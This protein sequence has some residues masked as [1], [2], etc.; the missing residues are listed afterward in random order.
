[1]TAREAH[2]IE[3]ARAALRWFDNRLKGNARNAMNDDIL[4]ARGLFNALARY[5]DAPAVA[6][7]D[8]DDPIT[9]VV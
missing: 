6:D 1:M 4:A 3:V 8:R 9:D 5:P 2:L 7:R